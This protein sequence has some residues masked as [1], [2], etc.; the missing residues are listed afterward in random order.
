VLRLRELERQLRE[1]GWVTAGEDGPRLSPKALRRLGDTALRKVFERLTT[2]AP[3]QHDL[4]SAGS[5]GEITGASRRW[6]YGDEQPIDVVRTV[7]NALRRTGR[8]DR[9]GRDRDSDGNQPVNL[10]VEDFEV[11][12]TERRASAAVA[13]CVDLSF[14]MISDGRWLPMKQTALALSRLVATRFRQDSCQIIGFGRYALP[15]TEEELATIEP[16]M[17]QGTNLQHALRLAGHHLRRHPASERIVMVVTDGEPTAHLVDNEEAVFC[18]PPAQETITATIA[19]VDNLT[20]LGAPINLFMLGEDEGLRRF[21]DAVARRCG[22]RV[23]TPDP[24][25][26]SSYVIAD[27]LRSR[28][29]RR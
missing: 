6:A 11:V 7:T 23:F 13:L 22:G 26:L 10:L 27:Y 28:N 29:G 4:R 25:D 16:N 14:S 5:A 20:R 3:G 24:E 15:L 18:W 2:G 8:E 19:E 17:I 12:E 9:A 1:Q 21:V